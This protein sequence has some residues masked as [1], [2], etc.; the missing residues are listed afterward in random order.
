MDS[1][2]GVVDLM[3]VC[4]FSDNVI[5]QLSSE[6]HFGHELW[7]VNSS[8]MVHTMQTE[9][10]PDSAPTASIIAESGS[11]VQVTGLFSYYTANTTSAAA[12]LV[13][14]AVEISV[15]VFRQWHSYHPM[16]YNC[17]FLVKSTSACVA[18]IDFAL[19]V[20]PQKP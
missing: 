1:G 16:F 6:H 11:K 5:Y 4:V 8:A 2:G 9:D 15:A 7:I 20:L 14:A 19:A 13:D 3:H 18:K 10:R 17:S 12:V